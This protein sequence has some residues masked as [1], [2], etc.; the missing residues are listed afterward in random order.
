MSPKIEEAL[1]E[2]LRSGTFRTA[3]QIEKWLKDEHQLEYGKGS[4]YVLGKLG[5]AAESTSPQPRKRDEPAYEGGS[6]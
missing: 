1:T 4:N 5:G 3:G 2:K 6:V